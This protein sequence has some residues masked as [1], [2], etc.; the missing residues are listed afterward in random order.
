MGLSGGI[1]ARTR[2][3]VACLVLALSCLPLAA[4]VKSADVSAPAARGRLAVGTGHSCAIASND[5]VW[6]WGD[7]T[8]GQ[9]G[10]SAHA[11]LPDS[12]SAVPVQAATLPAGRVA[13]HIASGD[14]HVCVLAGDG[15]VWCWGNNGF[16]E[17]GHP[18]LTNQPDPVQVTLP[19]P[20]TM[21]AAGGNSTCAVLTNSTV[22][23]WGRNNRGQLGNGSQQSSGGSATPTAVVSIP[24]SFVVSSL[25]LGATHACAT[26]AAGDTW[27]WGAYN[28]GR[29]G[30][31]SQS[32]NLTP[33]RVPTFGGGSATS[34]AAGF[35]HSCVVAATQ[36]WCFGSNSAGQ[37]GS[38]QNTVT[39]SS[40]P[41]SVTFSSSAAMVA[42]GREFTCALLVS[43]TVECFGINNSGQLGHSLTTPSRYTPQSVAGVTSGVVDIALGTKH[44]CAA[45]TTGAV[46]CWGDGGAGQLGNGGTTLQT[47]AVTVG[48]LN[49][50]PTTTTIATT[51]TEPTTTIATTTTEATTTS[52][53]STTLA[54]TINESTTSSSSSTSPPTTNSTL[55]GQ[56]NVLKRAPYLS[57]KRNRYLTARAIASHVSLT[58]PKTSQGSMRLTIVRGLQNCSFVDTKVRGIKKG[59]CSVLVTLIP[60]RGPRVLRTAKVVVS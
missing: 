42:T 52:T 51:T 30:N 20:A 47:S 13:R 8:F 50:A 6:C 26:S 39:E 28:N 45:L 2:V 15:T 43:Q 57:V 58:I 9:L 33:S 14:S 29:L 59:T 23:C 22:M 16:G 46:K 37:L 10:S 41:V 4:R 1:S 53:T 19:A 25:E 34:A 56:Q 18:S 11:G 40:T 27:C 48:T 3:C 17:V 5:V 31:T 24:S 55:S 36:A 54:I 7:N 60:K 35:S 38:D 44:A 32:D 12:A 49:I 21:V